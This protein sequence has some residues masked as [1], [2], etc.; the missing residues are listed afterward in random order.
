V[1]EYRA[2]NFSFLKEASNVQRL[3]DA[4]AAVMFLAIGVV[5]SF[6]RYHPALWLFVLCG[7]LLSLSTGLLMSSMRFT[8][9]LF[10]AFYWLA[11]VAEDRRVERAIVF[12]FTF[13]LALYSVMFLNAKWS[14]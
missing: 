1:R 10:P 12:A 9:V 14:G 13:F 8:A 4:S 6:K 7:V 3:M 11:E 2:F 5:M